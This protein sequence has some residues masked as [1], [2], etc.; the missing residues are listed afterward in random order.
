MTR[1]VDD[2]GVHVA[3]ARKHLF[4]KGLS[5]DDVAGMS[6]AEA[7]ATV[8]KD[9][10]WPVPDHAALVNAGVPAYVVAV[11]K[12]I[13]DRLPKLPVMV[14]P[15]Q[16]ARSGED[17]RKD[18]IEV[19]SIIRE[20]VESTDTAA[21]VEH[22][23]AR[24]LSAIGFHEG[25]MKNPAVRDPLD[26]IR[27]LNRRHYAFQVDYRDMAKAREMVDA[28]FPN[29][30]VQPAWRKGIFIRHRPDGTMVAINN[31]KRIVASGFR[32]EEEG[33]Q[34]LKTAW[35]QA[36]T[37]RS[38]SP[39]DP[40]SRPKDANVARIG[41]PDR[42]NGARISP[43]GFLAAFGFRAIQFG[44]SMS[45]V[46]RQDV[47]DSAHDALM[48][49]ADVLGVEPAAMSLHGRLAAAFGA[50]GSGGHPAHYEPGRR[51]FNIGRANGAGSLAHEWAHGLDDVLGELA[52]SGAGK[53]RTTYA[54]QASEMKG[55]S[56]ALE[57]Q[58]RG[59]VQAMLSRPLL[60]D[61]AVEMIEERIRRIEG[62]VLKGTQ[63]LDAA[64]AQA[65]PDRTYVKRMGQW[66]SA[67]TVAL[68]ALRDT[69]ASTLGRGAD[70]ICGKTP[71]QYV[72]EAN[73]LC[74]KS[75]E[76]W[77]RR[78]EL[79]A[80]AF[81]SVVFDS[82]AERGGTSG[83]LVHGVEPERY[84]DKQLYKGNPYPVGEERTRMASAILPAVRDALHALAP[85]PAQS[86]KVA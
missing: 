16:A 74:G 37:E 75:G 69:R 24:V 36:R 42:R 79:F 48:D 78:E 54:S 33:D 7:A 26:T 67:Q 85:A 86:P 80:R 46:E 11:A 4:G 47:V 58:W 52:T 23:Q 77:K 64:K 40:P 56:P 81:E 66:L 12:V 51:I 27:P 71:S 25:G 17:I 43:D 10:V 31:K 55:V 32:T 18:F 38:R 61:A 59:V 72:K 8:T 57:E 65:R 60:R 2:A 6:A 29:A 19:V 53:G 21:G 62:E 39:Q 73:D 70:E 3:G 76:Y 34:L 5:N 22:I 35:E 9:A 83:F 44:E 1:T 13:R 41:L 30:P 45:D 15:N 63:H 82:L 84:A 68:A 14:R 50:R 49:L 28:G 20:V